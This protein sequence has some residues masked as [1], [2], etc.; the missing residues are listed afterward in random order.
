MIREHLMQG[1][2]E[3]DKIQRGEGKGNGEGNESGRCGRRSCKMMT[4]C[5]PPLPR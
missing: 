5:S 3:R 4:L 1:G 2:R